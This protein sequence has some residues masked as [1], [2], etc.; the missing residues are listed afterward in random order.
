MEKKQKIVISK[1]GPYVVSGNIPLKKV[2]IV[3]DENGDSVDYKK[4][5]DYLGKDSYC[6]CRCGRSSNPPYCDTTH[7]DIN[8]QGKEVADREKY[9]DSAKKIEGPKLKLTDKESLCAL[10]RFCHNKKG[11]TWNL[12]ESSDKEDNKKEAIR[13]ACKC[14]SGRLVAWDDDEAIEEPLE[15]TIAL[16]YDEQKKV[17]GPLSIT[18]GI[19]IESSD[20]HVYEKRNRVTLCRCGKS[21]NMPFCDASH[22]LS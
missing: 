5:K 22:L 6:L 15:K 20:G 19:S 9:I 7:I 16:I 12:T 1:N 18:G 11:D 14:T 21:K 2:A 10:T 3:A 13:Q 8:F 4:E 17:L